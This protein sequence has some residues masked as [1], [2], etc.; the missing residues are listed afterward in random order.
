MEECPAE[1]FEEDDAFLYFKTT[2]ERSSYIAITRVLTPTP[3]WFV[4]VI[5]AMIA[6]IAVIGMYIYR[7]FKLATLRKTV[8]T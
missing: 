2:T 3:W 8:K 7:R 5:I 1:K 6:L 4:V